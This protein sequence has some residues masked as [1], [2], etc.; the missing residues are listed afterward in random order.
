MRIAVLGCGSIG[1]I[2]GA[3]LNRNGLQ[4]DL[5]DSYEEHVKVLNSNGAHIVDR[6]DFT[7]PVHALLPQDME[8][9]YDLVFLLT[10]QTSNAE[11]LKN[12]LPHLGE[13][14]TVCTLQNGVPEPYVAR[15][16]GEKRTVGG[17]VHWGATFMGPGVSAQTMDFVEGNSLFR[18]GEM[19]GRITDRIIT[20]KQVLD[21]MGQTD[22]T[23]DLMSVRW[24]K[25]MVN[26]CGSGMSAALGSPFGKIIDNSDALECMV[27]LG[28]ELG[29]C[30]LKA[31][32]QI[33][34]HWS[35]WDISQHGTK[36][37]LR[38]KF[39]ENYDFQREAKASMLQDLEKKRKTEVSMINGF[40]C[41]TG[42]R[43]GIETP[44]N[45]RVVEIVSK[46][47]EGELPLDMSNLEL[48]RD[49]LLK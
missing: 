28:Y 14:S 49:I 32:H 7:V 10:K 16:V 41:E 4:V 1:T 3:Y 29:L 27:Q 34:G 40:V 18:I 36:E 17:T 26:A 8:G 6:T 19:D 15:I 22:I 37:I 2:L 35:T 9:V 46:I 24:S 13:N 44:F 48:F 5:I 11:V 25:L 20:V 38:R 23:T 33:M 39:F 45:D 42:D 47:E 12:L 31:G 21:H 43:F 30:A